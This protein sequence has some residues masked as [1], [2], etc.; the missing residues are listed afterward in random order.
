MLSDSRA[1]SAAPVQRPSSRADIFLAFTGLALQGF[2]GVLA[3]SE[4]VLCE[5]KRWLTRTEF[6][7]LLALAQVLPGPNICNLA[8]MVG[9][10]F[11]GW[12]G[13]AAA[14]G[15]MMALPLG[16][17][18]SMTALYSHFSTIPAVGGAL[19]GM[20]AV[21][22]GMILGTAVR[23]GAGLRT[24]VLG[25]RLAFLAAVTAFVA[26]GVLRWPLIWTLGSLG[27][28]C[29]LLAAKWLPQVCDAR[30]EQ[31]DAERD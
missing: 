6:V 18:L 16:I 17:V 1:T 23:L 27:L 13:A 15:G 26:V 22:A 4:R 5:Q 19:R 28:A 11:F 8:V 20:A 12:R 9:D 7:E 10:R 29:C 3:V 24:N 25:V 31:V 21:S 30:N 2:G 14:L